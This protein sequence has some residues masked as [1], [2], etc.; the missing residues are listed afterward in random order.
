MDVPR[1]ITLKFIPLI[2]RKGDPIHE[3]VVTAEY[4][5]KYIPDSCLG[6]LMADCDIAID[7]L[8]ITDYSAGEWTPAC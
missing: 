1:T 7:C 5:L 4:V 8:T 2:V 6:T 3:R